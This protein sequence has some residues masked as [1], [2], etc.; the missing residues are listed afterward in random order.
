M[1]KFIEKRVANKIHLKALTSQSKA[2]FE[3]IKENQKQLRKHIIL[4]NELGIINSS[5]ALFDNKI[6]ILNFKKSAFGIL[7]DNPDMY[8]TLRTMFELSWLGAKP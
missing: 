4:D 3:L 8:D 5:I 2:H 7:I 6:L 1:Q